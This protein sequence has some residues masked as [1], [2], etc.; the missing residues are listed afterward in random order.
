MTTYTAIPDSDIDPESPITTTLM[1]RI[2]DN[3]IAITEGAAGAPPIANAALAGY[4]FSASAGDVTGLGWAL[5]DSWVPTAVASKDFTWDESLYTDIMIVTEG[6]IPATDG[7]TFSLQLGHTNGTVF[8]TGA[9]DYL[10]VASGLRTVDM[11]RAVNTDTAFEISDRLYGVGTAAGEG[12]SSTTT[13]LGLASVVNFPAL[14][15]VATYKDTGGVYTTIEVI[16]HGIDAAMD[17]T[18]FDAV[19]LL[20]STGNFEAA[21]KVWVYGLKRA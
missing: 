14:Q 9:S 17:T 19:R 12:L 4:P 1:T 3:P 7:A 10:W 5:L 2:R 18:V 8:F 15:S 16:G 20:W 11:P 13:L 6:I 21:G